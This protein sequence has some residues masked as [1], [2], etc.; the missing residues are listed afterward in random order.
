MSIICMNNMCVY[1]HCPGQKTVE[2]LLP[3]S[4]CVCVHIFSCCVY[5]GTISG[6]N[7]SC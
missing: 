4:L 2:K 3:A 5:L 1:R 7:P 6:G